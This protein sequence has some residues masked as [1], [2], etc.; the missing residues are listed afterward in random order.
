MTPIDGMSRFVKSK[1]AHYRAMDSV[2]LLVWVVQ[3]TGRNRAPRFPRPY[4][5]QVVSV[6]AKS[7]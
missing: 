3:N 6:L 1:G 5:L 7:Q 4:K 2:A